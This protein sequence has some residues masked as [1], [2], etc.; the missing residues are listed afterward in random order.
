M[1]RPGAEESASGV[2]PTALTERM[3]SNCAIPPG[4]KYLLLMDVG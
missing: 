1:L 2:S 4:Q 3:D